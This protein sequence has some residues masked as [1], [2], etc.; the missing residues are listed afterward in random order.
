M[1]A[2]ALRGTQVVSSHTR[3][4]HLSFKMYVTVR[5]FGAYRRRRPP[6]ENVYIYLYCCSR[7]SDR[8]YGFC[9][10]N[11]GT[12]TRTH[13]DCRSSCVDVCPW[14][15]HV[16]RPLSRPPVCLITNW[17]AHTLAH[18]SFIRPTLGREKQHTRK[19]TH[20]RPLTMHINTFLIE[21]RSDAHFLRCSGA[22][23]VPK[24]PHYLYSY[25]DC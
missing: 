15:T 23:R 20:A 13:A 22:E 8:A 11:E 18:H 19:H 1:R 9:R 24:S 10:T 4:T 2:P 3:N 6:K 5:M 12:R 21:I 7:G 25:F 14:C 16:L 17:R